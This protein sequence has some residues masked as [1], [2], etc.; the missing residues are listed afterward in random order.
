MKKQSVSSI[1]LFLFLSLFSLAGWSNQPARPDTPLAYL[2]AMV[3][4]HQTQN[5]EQLYLLQ[6]G[7]DIQSFR[8][9]HASREN[10]Q[11]AQL[12]Q[13]DSI[14]GEIILRGDTVSYFGDFQPFSLESKVILDNLPTVMYTDFNQL[15]DYNFIDIGR[16]RIADRIARVI[17]IVPRDDFRYQ[18]RVWI[19]EEN[20]LLLKSELIDRDNVVLEEFRV[21]Q[22]IV[23]EQL[24]YI[25]EPISS[26]ILPTLLPTKDLAEKQSVHW[27]PNWVPRGFK[28]L[29][30]GRQHLSDSLMNNED[31][32]SLQYSDGLFTFTIYVVE[33]TTIPFAEQFWR[34]GKMSVY[35][36][37][38]DNKDIVVVGEIPVVTARH[39]VQ[40]LELKFRS[41][42]H[43]K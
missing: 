24:L 10:K 16:E 13:L 9:R 6:N 41:G 39:L 42:E 8:Y 43:K 36:Q 3:Q 5:Y 40:D 18:Y 31:A 37:T 35:S 29:S 4:A 11:Y 7:E 12:L 25:I 28:V 17:R 33:N 2:N 20:Y 22:S 19:D 21:I 23:D 34:N 15:T 1:I 26:L 32:E 27:H 14:R 38:V 30:S